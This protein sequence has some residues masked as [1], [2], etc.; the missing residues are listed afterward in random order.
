MPFS[1]LT[2]SLSFP[3]RHE[4]ENEYDIYRDD[5]LAAS[6]KKTDGADQTYQ[7]TPFSCFGY[8]QGT[9]GNSRPNPIRPT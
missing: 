4:N 9:P 8:S 3:T 7:L 6:I 5:G 2:R 1:R